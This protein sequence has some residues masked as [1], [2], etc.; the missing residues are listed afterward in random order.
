M[1]ITKT[2]KMHSIDVYKAREDAAI[3]EPLSIKRDWMDETA[4]SHAYKCFPVSLT[5]GLGWGLSF[6]EDITFIWDGI[7]DTTPDHV[8]VISG[9]KYVY[10]E[11][12]NATLSF[13]TG[14]IFK[15]NSDVSMLQ[16]PVPNL[17]RD[18]IQPFTTIVSTSFFKGELPCAIRITRPN[19]EITIKA[20]TPIVSLFPISLTELNNSEM[21]LRPSSQ[22]P[23][24]FFQDGQAYS[25]KI[26]EINKEGRWS[27]FYRDAV[28]HLGMSVGKHE[29]KALR[30]KVIDKAHNE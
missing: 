6:P 4:D 3:L 12:A 8:K 15:T 7:S 25:Q 9:Q 22:I 21:T 30:L 5:N 16:M 26:A 17:F 10:T 24:D 1:E 27:N 19:V 18:G 29:V 28:N 13:N 11:R 14:L 2:Q 23:K 20:N